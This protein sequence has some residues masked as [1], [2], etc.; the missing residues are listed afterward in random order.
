MT[1]ALHI[2]GLRAYGHTG[3]LAEERR[4]GQW[5]EVELTLWLDLAPAAASDAI[6]DTFDYAKAST[7]V[8]HLIQNQS[9]QLIET[10]AAAIAQLL[11]SDRRLQQVRVQLTKLA[12]PIAN[13]TGSVTVD[14]TRSQERRALEQ[15]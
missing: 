10:L 3:L 4:L 11:L 13:F 15:Q 8:Q 5:F 6:A 12:P 7:S 14:I 2:S 9:F 1:D